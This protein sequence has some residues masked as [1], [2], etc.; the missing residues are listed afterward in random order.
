[1][2]RAPGQLSKPPADHKLR[3]YTP[4][5]ALKPARALSML[6]TDGAAEWAGP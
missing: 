5:D 4:D 1:M 3:L 2:V 6:P